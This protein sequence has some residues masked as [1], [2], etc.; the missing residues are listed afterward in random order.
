MLSIDQLSFSYGST[1]VLSDITFKVDDGENAVILGVNGEGKTTLLRCICGVLRPTNGKIFLDG[2]DITHVKAFERAR[3]I[4][5]VPQLQRTSSLTVFDTVLSGRRG[6]YSFRPGKSD[7]NRTIEV[8][9]QMGI[10]DLAVKRTCDL[11]GGELRKVSVARALC[12]DAKLMLMDEPTANLDI[13]GAVK[14]TQTIKKISK[15]NGVTFIV[16]MHDI[17]LASRFSDKI[18]LMKNGTVSASGGTE[19]LTPDNIK[20]VY[21]IEAS[22]HDITGITVA[23][24]K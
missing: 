15:Q 18:I 16:T 2:N 20:E 11:S 24:P 17:S 9:E 22:I 12:S 19:I 1:P 14:L 5:Y 23:V 6:T 8:I 7:R 13:G 3:L 4:A 10:A 21:G